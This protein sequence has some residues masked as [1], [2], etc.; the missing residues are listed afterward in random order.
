MIDLQI[1]VSPFGGTRAEVCELARRAVEGGLDGLALGDGMIGTPSY[2]I[3]QGGLDCFV[4]LA[5]LAGHFDLS[6]YGIEGI[7]LPARDPRI[8]AKQ[9]S[10]LAAVTDGRFHLCVLNGRWRHD[11]EVFGYDFEERGAR[12]DEG[13]RALQAIWRGEQEFHG[14]FWSWSCDAGTITPCM[15]APVPE[16]WLAGEGPMTIRRA[17]KY[18]LPWQPTRFTPAQ[19]APLAR[20]Y[21]ERGG[22]QLKIRVRATVIEPSGM[23]EDAL[24]YPTLIGPAAFLAEQFRGYQELGADYISVVPGFDYTSAAATIDALAEVKRSG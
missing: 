14:R 10:S 24:S 11:A 4:E 6:T 22:P 20:E 1:A 18:G 2:P 16:L 9:A 13:I 5:W 15:A 23:P 12:L 7:I 17:L 3:W 19:L 8:A 21:Y